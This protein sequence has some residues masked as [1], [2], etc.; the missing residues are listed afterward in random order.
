MNTAM[1]DEQPPASDVPAGYRVVEHVC[2]R[3]RPVLDKTTQLPRIRQV[4]Y[5]SKDGRWQYRVEPVLETVKVVKTQLY[6]LRRDWARQSGRTAMS[7]RQWRK[8]RRFC[9]RIGVVMD[10]PY[11]PTAAAA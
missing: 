7:G 2:S 4:G 6:S 11:V 9:Q 10:A 5:R 3:E 8:Y 1:Q